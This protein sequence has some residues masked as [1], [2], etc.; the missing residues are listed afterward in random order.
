MYSPCIWKDEMGKF[1]LN[2]VLVE[3]FSPNPY[4]KFTLDV[5]CTQNDQHIQRKLSIS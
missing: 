4:F 3:I 2:I 5:F 1:L